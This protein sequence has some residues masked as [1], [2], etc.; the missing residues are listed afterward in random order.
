ML[1]ILPA[2]EDQHNRP[3]GTDA[4]SSGSCL[5]MNTAA[6]HWYKIENEADVFTPTVLIDDDRVRCNLL[7]MLGW[8]REPSL[9][10]PHVKTHKLP[11][12]V[13][14]KL[15]AGITKFKCST[16]AEAEMTA[17]AGGEDILLAYQPVGPNIARLIELSLAFPN[18]RF[19]T[20]VDDSTIASELGTNAQRAGTTVPTFVD[21]NVGMNR[22]GI[23]PDDAVSLCQHVA[24][25][26]GLS[27]AGLHAYEGHLHSSDLD[28]LREQ[29]EVVFRGVW[30]LKNR[31]EDAG[32]AVPRVVGCGTPTS[33]L[34]ASSDDVEIEVSAGTSVFWDAGQ[35]DLTP[36]VGI[37][38][39]AVVMC[40]VIS[41]P[42]PNRLCLD[43]GHKA[44]ASEFPA[45]RVRLFGLESAK[46]VLHSE[47]HL[48]IE[49]DDAHRYPI[50]AVL[51]GIPYHICP[52]VAL[53]SEVWC[54][55][56][57]RADE[58]W[59]VVARARRLTI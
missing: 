7:T 44:I 1:R 25:I 40:R 19:S 42:T 51:Y 15:E 35:P 3:I 50:G 12:I 6:P 54:V 4:D 37:I 34:M 29:A 21:L 39:A 33:R 8:V 56:D 20:I 59:P 36:E 58:V 31:L 32:L 48:V 28:V 52:T 46:E 5:H 14:L 18:A 47:E 30:N 13:R 22:T 43:L 16:I 41:K 23:N 57:G 26:A 38:N 27:F 24:R 45:P 9:L 55:R 49:T 11:Q 2:I 17:R 53:H 10:R